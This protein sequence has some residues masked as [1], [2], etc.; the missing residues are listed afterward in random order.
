MGRLLGEPHPHLVLLRTLAAHHRKDGHHNEDE[1]NTQLHIR[2]PLQTAQEKRV[3]VVD[4]NIFSVAHGKGDDVMRTAH[5]KRGSIE[6]VHAVFWRG[7]V[8]DEV[9]VDLHGAVRPHHDDGNGIVALYHTE[10]QRHISR[11][12]GLG[13]R[14]HR[15]G[16]H[17]HLAHL[18]RFEVAHQIMGDDKRGRR[19]SEGREDQEDFNLTYA[20][21]PLHNRNV[22]AQAFHFIALCPRSVLVQLSCFSRV[23]FVF[24]PCF[25]AETAALQQ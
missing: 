18:L 5:L 20:I 10:H 14:A 1:H 12:V 3:V 19:Y 21:C 22:N 23:S 13:E 15:F 8:Q 16:P 2:P 6:L 11:L 24:L 9:A 7:I 4:V 17:L 25:C